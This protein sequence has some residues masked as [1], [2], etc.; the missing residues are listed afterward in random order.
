[1]PE[2]CGSHG[3]CKTWND[4]AFENEQIC[5]NKIQD[6][7]KTLEDKSLDYVDM[8][9]WIFTPKSFELLIGDL[10][11]LGFID[12]AISKIEKSFNPTEFFVTLE[13]KKLDAKEYAK[14]R[15]SLLQSIYQYPPE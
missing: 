2:R 5:Y 9:R 6:A 3:K 14:Q 13:K 1:M 4:D 12:M 7:L 10:N 15:L 8:H 11:V